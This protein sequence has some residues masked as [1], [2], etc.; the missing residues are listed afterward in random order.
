MRIKLCTAIGLM[1]LLITFVW[2]TQGHCA[3]DFFSGNFRT[4]A[5][6]VIGKDETVTGSLVMT[7]ANIKVEG[8]IGN[9]LTAFGANVRISG[10]VNGE[11]FVAG[12]NVTLSGVF[13]DKVTVSAARTGSKLRKGHPSQNRPADAP[14]QT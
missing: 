2:S 14:G 8:V 6:V 9:K 4:G 10:N 12:A 13:R 1:V 11:L 3:K 7:G 5:N